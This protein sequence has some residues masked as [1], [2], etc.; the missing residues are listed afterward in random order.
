MTVLDERLRYIV[1]SGRAIIVGAHDGATYFDTQV[2]KQ[3]SILSSSGH[4][5]HIVQCP[6]F[7]PSPFAHAI[8]HEHI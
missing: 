4:A 6:F 1:Q 2:E 8:K 5:N 3:T 7:L